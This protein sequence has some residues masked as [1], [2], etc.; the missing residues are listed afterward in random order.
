MLEWMMRRRSAVGRPREEYVENAHAHA[1]VVMT[2]AFLLLYTYL[3]NRYATTV[4]LTFAEIEDLL[5]F[6][7]PD[8]ARLHSAWWTNARSSDADANHS[9]SWILADRTAVPNLPAQ[10]VTF[11]RVS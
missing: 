6:A 9:D 4:V 7:L 5:G 1:H 8:Q 10:T 2:G 3:N 11:E